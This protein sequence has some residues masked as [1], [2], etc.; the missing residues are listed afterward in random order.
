MG[1]A[2]SSPDLAWLD[3]AACRGHEDLFFPPQGGR[4]LNAARELC[5]TCPV[6]PECLAYGI[7]LRSRNKISNGLWGGLLVAELPVTR[8]KDARYAR[9][10]LK[11]M[12]G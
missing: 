1:K 4:G 6:R 2:V 3:E 7:Y 12:R 9:A 10:Q 8:F 5:E 11:E